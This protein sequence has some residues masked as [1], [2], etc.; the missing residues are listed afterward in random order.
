MASA[1]ILFNVQFETVIYVFP[2]P[3][4]LAKI[5]VPTTAE[6]PPAG[7]VWVSEI[8]ELLIVRFRLTLVLKILIKCSLARVIVE[9]VIEQVP[10]RFCRKTA[11]SFTSSPELLT[12]QLV[13]VKLLL[14]IPEIP[15]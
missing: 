15:L 9:P 4:V 3:K 12:V 14:F 10:E 13:I 6:A 11:P 5:P 8:V 1:P 7:V 2:V